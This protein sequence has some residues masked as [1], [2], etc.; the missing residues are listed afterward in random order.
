MSVYC[1]EQIIEIPHTRRDTQESASF[2]L[3]YPEPPEYSDTTMIHR[4]ELITASLVI[5]CNQIST[6]VSV[7]C[8]EIPV[9]LVEP[10]TGLFKLIF[11][12]E[13]WAV[14]WPYD[15]FLDTTSSFDPSP[16]TKTR[17]CRCVVRFHGQY[18]V[19]KEGAVEICFEFANMC[20]KHAK[21]EYV[22]V[23]TLLLTNSKPIFDA[24]SNDRID[25]N[26]W[27]TGFC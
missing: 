6:H 21:F 18:F 15:V 13:L 27:A 16:V 23:Y 5:P 8:V 11:K 25:I 17:V 24:Q 14:P 22:N 12:M 4:G 1:E 2:R 20:K 7:K 10:K 19:I 26:P 3:K 9:T